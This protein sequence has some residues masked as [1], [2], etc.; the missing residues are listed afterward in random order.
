MAKTDDDPSPIGL[1]HLNWLVEVT[2][3][4]EEALAVME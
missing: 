4:L 1:G 2:Q 3:L